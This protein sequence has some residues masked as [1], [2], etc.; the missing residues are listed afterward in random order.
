MIII[1]P[2]KSNTNFKEI[3]KDYKKMVNLPYLECPYCESTELVR[4]GSYTRNINYIWNNTILYETIDIK[5][6]R[7]KDCGH[8]HALIPSFIVPYKVNT[9]D[10]IL[11]C[12]SFDNTT[13]SFSFDTI[14]L[15]NKQFNK[16]LPYL[17][18]MFN[19]MDKFQI[20]YELKQNIFKYY[21]SFYKLNKKILMMTH[22]G[23][24]NMAYF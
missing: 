17:K 21:L 6:V 19:N 22:Y 12:T 7:C 4:W 3:L 13:V 16:F 18:T 15:I 8:T 10:T 2:I 9:L 5:R 14:S 11:A 23:V 24:L 1:N 20:I